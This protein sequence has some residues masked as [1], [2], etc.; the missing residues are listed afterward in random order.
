MK[1]RTFLQ[2]SVAALAA[3]QINAATLDAAGQEETLYNGIRLP[4]EWPPRIEYTREPMRVPYLQNPPA[5]IPIDVGRQLFVD[6]F[7]IDQTNLTRT[8][9]SARYHD[10]TPILRPD[11]L[12]TDGQNP[13]H[14]FPTASGSDPQD[15][16]S[17][18]GTWAA[19]SPTLAMR[20]PRR[21]QVGQAATDVRKDTNIVVP[22]FRD[23][24]TVWLDRREGRQTPLQDVPRHA[25]SRL[26]ALDVQFSADGIHW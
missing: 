11:R 20:R 10:A 16:L 2:A 23:S 5:V 3:T 8:L 19:C 7:L 17:R 12:G 15:S 25:A 14:G 22:G 13:R 18:C 4:A 9:H 21:H 24:N 26:W 6:N 1:R